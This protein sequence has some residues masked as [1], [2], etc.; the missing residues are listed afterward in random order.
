MINIYVLS[1]TQKY[2]IIKLTGNKLSL[3]KTGQYAVR[4]HYLSYEIS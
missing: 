4:I 3:H 1:Q 2:L